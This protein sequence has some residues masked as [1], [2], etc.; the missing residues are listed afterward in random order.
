MYSERIRAEALTGLASGR[1]LSEVS[2]ELAISRSTLRAWRDFGP[3]TGPTHSCP[4]CDDTELAGPAY[5]ALLGYYLGDG[6]VSAT[7]RYFSLRVSCD[8]NWP[9]IVA[10][11]A[12]ALK[13]VRPG[14]NVFR[15]SAPGVVVVAAHWKHWPCRRAGPRRRGL[16]P[17]ELGDRQRLAAGGRR[18]SGRPDRPQAVTGQ[19]R[20]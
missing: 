20:R 7:P 8:A 19:F 14:A 18:A 5:A 12:G 11:V 2:R 4:R 15:V 6:C 13:G 16:A 10:D 9:G 3:A 17:V 1:S